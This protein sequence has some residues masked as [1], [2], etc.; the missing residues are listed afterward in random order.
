M[1]LEKMEAIPSSQDDK[2]T[3]VIHEAFNWTQSEWLY[4][5]CRLF[6]AIPG[7]LPPGPTPLIHQISPLASRLARD[8]SR[9]RPSDR[10]YSPIVKYTA[11]E[12]AQSPSIVNFTRVFRTDATTDVDQRTRLIADSAYTIGYRAPE[13]KPASPSGSHY[14]VEI[15]HFKFGTAAS[16][17]S[18]RPTKSSLCDTPNNA[19][20]FRH[21]T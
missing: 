14:A 4:Q 13:S 10:C 7:T 9:R 1:M 20:L 2:E 17:I 12:L 15:R 21:A 18:S 3:F 16:C 5:P 19:I 8:N 11:V 6:G